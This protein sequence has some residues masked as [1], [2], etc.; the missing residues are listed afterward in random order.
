M[1]DLLLSKK[2]KYVTIYE[3]EMGS[4]FDHF[5]DSSEHITYLGFNFQDGHQINSLPPEKVYKKCLELLNNKETLLFS[6]F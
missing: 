6:Q 1:L 2:A 3:F 4:H 5:F